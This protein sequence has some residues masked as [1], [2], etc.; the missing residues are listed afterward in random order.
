M[1]SSRVLGRIMRDAIGAAACG[2]ETLPLNKSADDIYNAAVI[3]GNG[4]T[5]ADFM[6][7]EIYENCS[8]M[9]PKDM[10]ERAREVLNQAISELTRAVEAI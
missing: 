10:R 1:A 6:A 5:L 4:D 8:E 7:I 9:E 3:G 2:I